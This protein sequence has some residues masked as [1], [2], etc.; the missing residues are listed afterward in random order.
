MTTTQ[1]PLMTRPVG[2]AMTPGILTC[3]RTA[4]LRAV[5]ALMT[6]HRVHAIVVF[7]GGDEVA[8]WGVIS[9]LDLVDAIDTAGSAG[10]V[11]ASPVVTVTVDDTLAHAA[12]L[13]REHATSHL[14]VVTDEVSPL[15]IG[16]LSTLDVARAFA[17]LD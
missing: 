5:A 17:E 3:G 13:M 12:Q 11:A 7:A 1:T 4:P 15:P 8:P 6:K 2:E 16:V 10:S 9:D 14:I